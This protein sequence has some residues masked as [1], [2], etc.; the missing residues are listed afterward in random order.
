MT[1]RDN[2]VKALV[3]LSNTEEEADRV[4]EQFG[5]RRTCQEKIIFL[6]EQFPNISI[7]AGCDGPDGNPIQTDYRALLCAVV[8]SKWR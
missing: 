5:S 4:I 2:I 3:E 6:S 7:V 8:N 1:V